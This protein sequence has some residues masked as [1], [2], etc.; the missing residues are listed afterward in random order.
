MGQNQKK[1]KSRASLWLLL[2]MIGVLLIGIAIV[3]DQ[4]RRLTE[5]FAPLL[6]AGMATVHADAQATAFAP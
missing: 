3:A 6:D 5:Q 4:N 2:I 1:P